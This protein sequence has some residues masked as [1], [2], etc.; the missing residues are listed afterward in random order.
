MDKQKVPY[1]FLD[2]NQEFI[3]HFMKVLFVIKIK[4][5]HFVI[6]V[7]LLQFGHVRTKEK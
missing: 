3:K 2:L 4:R 6:S 7:G 1:N 5:I